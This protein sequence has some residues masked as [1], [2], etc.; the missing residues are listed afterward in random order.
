[1]SFVSFYF[2]SQSIFDNF[3]YSSNENINQNIK[4]SI[5]SIEAAKNATIQISQN[6]NII[7]AITQNEYDPTVNPILNT[8]KNTSYGIL[9]VTLYTMNNQVYITSSV[10]SYPTLSEILDNKQIAEFIQSDKTIYL[11]IRTETITDIY[12]H[13]RYDPAYGM[14]SYIVKLYDD[15][16]NICGYLFVDINPSYI[17]GNFFSYE[18]YQNFKSAKTYIVSQD[19]S[20]LKSN[21]NNTQLSKYITYQTVDKTQISKDRKYLVITKPYLDTTIVSVIPMNSYYNNLIWIGFVLF[22]TSIFL[23]A[24]AYIVASKL[25]N[26]IISSLS[27]LHQKIQGTDLENG[28]DE[29]I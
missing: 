26:N 2:V 28:S 18:N 6:T 3:M 27:H 22:F 24:I 5:F 9:G 17:Y 10:T 15:D 13:V 20:Y 12:N 19:G 29:S 8:L 1:M 25:S 16:L 4:N 21:Y 23:I 7:E 14:I 11:S